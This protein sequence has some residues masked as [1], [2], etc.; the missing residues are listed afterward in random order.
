MGLTFNYLLKNERTT[1]TNNNIV[2]ETLYPGGNSY[3]TL[4]F[5]L[6]ANH[7]LTETWEF[8]LLGGMNINKSDFDTQVVD[9][10]QFPFFTAVAQKRVTHTKGTPYFNVSTT[11]RWTNWTFTAG[12][13]RDQS[14][15]AY[16]YVT[17]FTRIY[18][19]VGHSLTERCDRKLGGQ[20]FFKFAGFSVQ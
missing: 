1:L 11:R 12:F 3:K 20:L 19:S 10:S 18:A 14:P 13:S 4:G 17:N 2:R 16:G 15:S 8:N 6:G 5:Y 7:K 9:F